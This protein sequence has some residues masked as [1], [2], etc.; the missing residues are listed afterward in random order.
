VLC[1]GCTFDS[2]VDPIMIS[3]GCVGS[4]D[5]HSSE[6]GNSSDT[7][8]GELYGMALTSGSKVGVS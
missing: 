5:S 8:D 3:L 4:D 6:E 1:Q 7:K 2:A